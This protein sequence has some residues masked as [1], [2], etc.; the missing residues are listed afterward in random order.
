MTSKEAIAVAFAVFA[1]GVSFVAGNFLAV[2]RYTL[3]R[4][5]E[6]YALRLDR[7]TGETTAC[8]YWESGEVSCLIIGD[9]QRPP[10]E[11]SFPERSAPAKTRSTS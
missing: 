5:D 3:V 11:Q 7:W 9:E 8:V 10:W 4:M 1:L 2:P 6:N